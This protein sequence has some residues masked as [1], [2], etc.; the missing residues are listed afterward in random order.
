MEIEQWRSYR[1]ESNPR[2]KNAILAQILRENDGFIVANVRRLMKRGLVSPLSAVAESPL[3][4]LVQLGRIGYMKAL[5]KFDPSK[6][7][8]PTYAKH[9][10]RHEVQQGAIAEMTIRKPKDSG[11]PYGTLK[12]IEEIRST[13]GREVTPEDLD[14]SPDRLE[15]WLTA[16]TVTSYQEDHGTGSPSPEGKAFGGTEARDAY[17]GGENGITQKTSWLS[18]EDVELNPEE[19]TGLS[20]LRE[21]VEA[22]PYFERQVLEALYFTDDNV[23]QI[24]ARLKIACSTMYEIRDAA[25]KKLRAEV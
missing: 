7:A 14:I 15:R 21:R 18:N 4:D 11:L 24:L 23:S 16:P 8:F 9:W 12:K 3:E 17:I 10:I 13:T 20:E 25:L 2:R 6:G 22:L 19:L 1:D 5:D